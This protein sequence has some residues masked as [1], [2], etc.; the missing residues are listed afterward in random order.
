MGGVFRREKTLCVKSVALGRQWQT[1]RPGHAVRPRW[2]MGSKCW[3]GTVTWPRGHRALL[4]RFLF[5]LNSPGK[6][7]QDGGRERWTPFHLEKSS[8]RGRGASD[9]GR[10]RTEMAAAWWWGDVGQRGRP[11]GATGSDI[12]DGLEDAIS[13]MIPRFLFSQRDGR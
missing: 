10:P 1:G 12:S 5:I 7:R 9:A 4:G 2:G 6:C 13:R 8:L 3:Q 11:H